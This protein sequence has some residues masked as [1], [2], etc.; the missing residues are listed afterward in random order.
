MKT[1]LKLLFGTGNTVDS[2]IDELNKA[3]QKALDKVNK[4][5]EDASYIYTEVI[6]KIQELELVVDKEEQRMV[7]LEQLRGKIEERMF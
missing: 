5:G 7:K 1:L 6:N 3:Y 2:I 4:E